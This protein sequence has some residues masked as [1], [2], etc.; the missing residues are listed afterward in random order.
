MPRETIQSVKAAARKARQLLDKEHE[1]AIERLVGLHRTAEIELRKQ[2]ADKN[3]ALEA[4]RV[5]LGERSRRIDELFKA[6][7]EYQQ[8]ARDARAQTVRLQAALS[9][10]S[11][12]I[13]A[14]GERAE[15]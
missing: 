12:L 13:A 14:L 10:A 3:G 8:E 15:G 5:E 9:D 4:L 6:N 7:N 1:A 11:R 2:I